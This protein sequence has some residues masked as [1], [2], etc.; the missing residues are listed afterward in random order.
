MFQ[1]NKMMSLK[2]F[3]KIMPK[4][5]QCRNITTIVVINKQRVVTGIYPCVNSAIRNSFYNN[6]R[7]FLSTVDAKADDTKEN[8][9]KADDSK[10]KELVIRRILNEDDDFHDDYQGGQSGGSTVRH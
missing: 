9:S 5:N 1:T 7:R 8:E 10:E 3:I 4:M 6:Q 2:H